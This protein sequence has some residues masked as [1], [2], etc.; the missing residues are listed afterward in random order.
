MS[1]D[2]RRL[3]MSQRNDTNSSLISHHSGMTAAP[4]VQ[5]HQDAAASMLQRTFLTVKEVAAHYAVSVPTIWR[6]TRTQGG[7]FPS[8][9]RIA[10][11]TTRW[12]LADLIDFDQACKARSDVRS[13]K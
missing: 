7:T 8:P 2:S 9:V 5:P 6:W 13:S 10:E 11:G 1:Y 3:G 4:S 12:D